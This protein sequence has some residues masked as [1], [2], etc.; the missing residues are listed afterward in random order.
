MNI[1]MKGKVVGMK[2]WA[3]GSPSTDV[4]VEVYANDYPNPDV[5]GRMVNRVTLKLIT[6]E[7]EA[8]K[9]SYN[10]KVTVRIET[11]ER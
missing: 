1:T 9:L 11:A 10:E 5:Q 2:P 6:S 8:S 4:E 7:T 3:L